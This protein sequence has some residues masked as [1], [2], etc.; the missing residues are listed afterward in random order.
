MRRIAFCNINCQNGVSRDFEPVT[1]Q[2][3]PQSE[4]T[5]GENPIALQ[6]SEQV[7]I[8][9]SSVKGVIAHDFNIYPGTKHRIDMALLETSVATQLIDFFR[10]SVL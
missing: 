3:L 1:W 6:R 2:A 5:H 7:R 9:F 8:Q 10:R 4:S